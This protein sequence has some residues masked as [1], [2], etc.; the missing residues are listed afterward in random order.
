MER[1]TTEFFSLQVNQPATFCA[2]RLETE[3]NTNT[4]LVWHS[5]SY[6]RGILLYSLLIDLIHYVILCCA[7]SKQSIPSIGVNHSVVMCNRQTHIRKG[8]HTLGGTKR[9]QNIIGYD[10][11]QLKVKLDQ[12]RHCN[13]EVFGLEAC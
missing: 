7:S 6:L 11:F 12:N 8:L 13:F 3:S 4:E 1:K 9:F 5:I 2:T 10:P